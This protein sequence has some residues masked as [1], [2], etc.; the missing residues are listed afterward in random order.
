MLTRIFHNVIVTKSFSLNQRSVE[1][2]LVS[3]RSSLRSSI[4]HVRPEYRHPKHPVTA[5]CGVFVQCLVMNPCSIFFNKSE[6]AVMPGANCAVYGCSACKGRN[7]GLSFFSIR[8]RKKQNSEWEQALIHSVNRC[9]KSF[10]IERATICSRHFAPECI[11]TTAGGKRSLVPGSL[12]TLLIP[13]RSVETPK[14]QPRKPPTE[15]PPPQLPK[16]V[17]YYTFSEVRKAAEELPLPWIQISNMEQEIVVATVEDSMVK[18][19]VS[20][21]ADFVTTVQV[22]GFSAPNETVNI[23]NLKLN[24]FLT[25]LSCKC[26]CKGVISEP[27]Q[28]FSALPRNDQNQLYFRHVICTSVGTHTST[29]RS[30]CCVLL[31]E[32]GQIC[33][34]CQYVERL[35]RMKEKRA[36]ASKSSCIKT[37]HSLNLPREKLKDILKQTRKYSKAVEQKLKNFQK[38]LNC[39]KCRI[40]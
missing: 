28:E 14:S 4:A 27:L 11:V 18:F 3:S 34:P 31:T 17:A 21:K 29:V 8:Q 32:N 33:E 38:T 5:F 20:I 1:T 19:K 40:K 13:P 12:P 10:N 25:N 2:G 7:R 9:D 37:N 22:Y 23:E 16:T 30:K 6:K 36:I 39:R 24:T 35:L 15:R 26:V